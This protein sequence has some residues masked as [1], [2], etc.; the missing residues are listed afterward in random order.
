[1]HRSGRPSACLS[2]LLIALVA[3]VGAFASPAGAKT[4]ADGARA[5][6]CAKAKHRKGR[7]R[8]IR[9]VVRRLACASANSKRVRKTCRTK[10]VRY[11]SCMRPRSRK[12]RV[13]CV[14]RVLRRAAKATPRRNDG[15]L[16]P[17]AGDATPAGAGPGRIAYGLN[18]GE[19]F[20]RMKAALPNLTYARADFCWA[21]FEPTQGSYDWRSIDSYVLDAARQGL[22]A[23]AL[24]DCS[25]S[26]TGLKTFELPTG[27]AAMDAYTRMVGDVVA[28]YGPGGAVWREHPDVPY[29][30][31]T[32]FEVWNEPYLQMFM[33]NAGGPDPAIYARLLRAAAQ[34]GHARNPAVKFL[35]SADTY[36]IQPNDRRTPWVD[37]MYNA[38]PDLN[39]YFDAVAVHPYAAHGRPADD[40]VAGD[41]DRQY[42]RR[43]EE[44]R[45]AFVAHGAADKHFWETEV[46][47]STCP[48]SS[49]CVSEQKQAD[50]LAYVIR[51]SQSYGWVD[52][53][54]PY[55]YR[56]DPRI[57]SYPT[58]P[59]RGYGLLRPDFS[60]KPA[61]DVLRRATET[62]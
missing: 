21:Q 2:V 23:L 48:A 29:H 33:Q 15:I 31:V 12:K 34:A 9:R 51:M 24:L 57:T 58:D 40:Y 28:R 46:G 55:R 10:A 6:K 13:R 52:A 22:T 20:D 61:F 53:I 19:A 42:F 27:G 49:D 7:M 41:K 18:A 11:R 59:E 39:S 43:I 37:A 3:T 60:P 35:A 26:W 54:L 25:P 4:S 62:P 44:V 30:P 38:V 14:R 32:W 50:Y 36:A 8:C 56:D 17:P 5:L 47:W 45:A 16:A 1:M